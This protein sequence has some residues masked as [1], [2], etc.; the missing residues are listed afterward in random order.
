MASLAGCAPNPPDVEVAAPEPALIEPSRPAPNGQL[1][2]AEAPTLLGRWEGIGKQDSGPTWKM[3]LTIESLDKGKCARVHYPSIP[4][5]GHWLCSKRSDGFVLEGVEHI[6]AGGG[7]C[8]TNVQV[9]VR[10][11]R[12]RESIQFVVE[13]GPDSAEATLKRV[14]LPGPE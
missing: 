13:A 2:D 6:T 14:P 7:L 12:D 9:M 5:G 1:P 8:H 3:V 11:A 4:C 10:L